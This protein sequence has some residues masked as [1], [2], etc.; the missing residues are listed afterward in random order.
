MVCEGPD[1]PSQ[2]KNH[3][4]TLKFGKPG[5]TWET[6]RLGNSFYKEKGVSGPSQ[7]IPTFKKLPIEGGSQSV[8]NQM[9]ITNVTN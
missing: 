7:T 9:K 1:P 5:K 6:S 8:F 2:Y 3:F 4:P